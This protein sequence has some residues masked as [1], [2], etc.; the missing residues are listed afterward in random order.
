MDKRTL[1]ALQSASSMCDAI[2]DS[3]Q[4]V[5]PDIFEGAFALDLEILELF[6]AHG[7]GNPD[8][9]STEEI[10]QEWKEARLAMYGSDDPKVT[11]K[12]GETIEPPIDPMA[13]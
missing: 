2:R 13:N 3:V 6:R 8:A 7:V 1:F 12:M 9:M 4:I 10:I 5:L 11:I